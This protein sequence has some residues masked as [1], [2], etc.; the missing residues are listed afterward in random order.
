MQ[1]T[2][3]SFWKPKPLSAVATPLKPLFQPGKPPVAPA[4]AV[5]PDAAL[6][7]RAKLV[8][9]NSP[10]YQGRWI[11]AIK[12]LRTGRGW[13]LEGSTHSLNLDPIKK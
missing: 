4:P 10:Y 3:N 9:P 2:T 7:A 6:I 5:H 12:I 11:R 13:L 1:P 8:W